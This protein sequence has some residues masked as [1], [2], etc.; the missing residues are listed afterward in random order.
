MGWRRID[1]DGVE[2]AEL[3]WDPLRIEGEVVFAEDRRPCAV[4]YRVDCDDRG[5]T[6]RAYV[7]VR[8]DGNLCA[9]TLVRHREGS[10]TVDG[11]PAPRLQGLSDVDLSITP[12]TNSLPIRRLGLGV[13]ERADVSAA[14]MQFP[15]LEVVVLRQSYRRV[16]CG[17]YEYEAPEHAF[18][19]EMT[20]DPDGIVLGYGQL[21][22]RLGHS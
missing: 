12:S 15:S 22:A 9:R 20:V 2:Y 18:R 16:E 10:W 1:T 21:W 14:W 5:M 17:R 7:R 13:G 8:R 11:Q 4:S 6:S 19:G 3:E